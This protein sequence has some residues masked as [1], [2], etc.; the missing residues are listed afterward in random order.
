M[1]TPRFKKA[2]AW[3]VLA[4]G[5]PALLGGLAYLAIGLDSLGTTPTRT[6]PLPLFQNI[7][8]VLAALE[9]WQYGILFLALLAIVTACLSLFRRKP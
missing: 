7:R 6:D 4:L 3:L 2:V 9:W 8:A 5:M 1:L